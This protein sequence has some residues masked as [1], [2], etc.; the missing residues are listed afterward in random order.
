[1]NSNS[2]NENKTVPR[3]IFQQAR[4]LVLLSG[5][6]L[7]SAAALTMSGCGSSNSASPAS[8]VAVDPSFT[9]IYTNVLSQNC[10]SCHQPGG[11]GTLNGANLDF[12]SQSQAYNTI[13]DMVAGLSSSG[14]TSLHNVVASAPRSSYL[15]AVID[16]SYNR[17]GFGAASGCQPIASHV[18]G[19]YASPAAQA[20]IVTWITNG[21]ANN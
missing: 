20:A 14:C 5:V 6:A 18:S 3:S 8:N 2:K 19:G 21:A 10:A 13:F 12:S 9:S 17:A 1:M 7:A 16:S 15:L 4:V 11:S